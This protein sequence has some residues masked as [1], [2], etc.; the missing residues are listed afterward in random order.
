MNCGPII[1]EVLRKITHDSRVVKQTQNSRV[2]QSAL[3][4]RY[5][6]RVKS[7]CGI[8]AFFNHIYSKYSEKC[9]TVQFRL[10]E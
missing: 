5:D 10:N 2:P 8:L 3:A 4:C 7:G 9:T 6:S 1:S